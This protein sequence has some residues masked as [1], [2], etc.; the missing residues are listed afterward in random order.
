MDITQKVK[1]HNKNAVL[2]ATNWNIEDDGMSDIYWEQGISQFWTPEEFD[3]SRDL[4]SWNSLTESEKNTYKKVLAGLTGLDTKQG[5]EGM[6]LVSYHEP[7]PKYQAVFAFMGGMEEIHAKSYSH[8]FTTLLS[9]KETSYLLD[10]WVEENDFLKVKAQF[11]GYYYDQ[12]LKPNPTIFDRYMAKVASAFLES[13]LFYSG[14]YYPLLL[15]GRG[16]MT[17]SG[18]IIYKITQDEAYHGSAV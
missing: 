14:F 1:Q 8:I 2:K 6:N 15:A 7:R 10:T 18:A 17:Q 16:Q 4:S 12:L 13:A 3:V 11:I 5:G 9:N